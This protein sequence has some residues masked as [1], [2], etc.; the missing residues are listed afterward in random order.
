M[1]NIILEP[2]NNTPAIDFSINGIMKIKGRSLT[3]SEK[4]FY[5]P[6]IEW[7]RHVNSKV[8][9]LDIDL[10]Y[11]NSSS[12]KNILEL[13]KVLNDNNEINVLNINWYF[14]HNDHDILESGKIFAELLKKANFHY[15][16]Y[17]DND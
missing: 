17:S 13:L 11:I 4:N 8:I 9:K 1:K 16:E 14:E 3:D 5:T 2:T 7:A 15:I 6:L 12:A 10:E